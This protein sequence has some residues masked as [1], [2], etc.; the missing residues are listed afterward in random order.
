MFMEDNIVN[1]AKFNSFKDKARKLIHDDAVNDSKI[2]KERTK[3]RA[4]FLN[5]TVNDASGF[6]GLMPSYSHSTNPQSQ[7]QESHD[8]YDEVGAHGQSIEMSLNERMEAL[9]RKIREKKGNNSRSGLP[10]EILESFGNTDI[11]YE[12]LDPNQSVLDLIG[13]EPKDSIKQN[14]IKETTSNNYSNSNVDYSLIKSI[15]ESAVKKYIG[16]YTKKLLEE[17]KKT[18]VNDP[19]KAIKIGDKFSFITENGDIYEAK[20]VFKKNINK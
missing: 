13:V 6:E 17:G 3:D 2:I 12:K 1:A 18:Q 19:V 9:N 4:A 11:N 20:L 8:E 15:V 10:M 16:G 7:I 5:K 14:V